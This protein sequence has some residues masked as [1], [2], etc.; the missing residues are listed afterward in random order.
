MGS[1]ERRIGTVIGKWRVNSVLG[2]GSM[3]SV[4]GVTHRNGSRAALKV[5]HAALC[6]DESLVERFFS[7]GYLA[8]VVTHPGI[9]R[10][11]D[12]GMTE[13]GCP[14]LAMEL[15]RGETLEE[16]RLRLGGSLPV[17]VALGITDSIL[18]VLIAV[19]GGD[20]I[21][22]DLKPSNVFLT[23]SGELK[24]LD[25]GVAKLS[26]TK[27]SSKGSLAG[28]VLGTPAYMSPE[29]AAGTG[30]ELDV[31]ADLFAV[32]AIMFTMLSGEHVHPVEG[33]QKKLLAAATMRARPV[34]AVLPALPEEIANVIDRALMFKKEDRWPSAAQMRAA[35][36]EARRDAVAREGPESE[37]VV[38]ARPVQRDS[39]LP[40]TAEASLP[41]VPRATM[42]SYVSFADFKP[43]SSRGPSPSY[44]SFT[45]FGSVPPPPPKVPTFGGFASVAPPFSKSPVPGPYGEAGVAPVTGLPAVTTSRIV[46]LTPPA[47]DAVRESP[48]PPPAP[49]FTI[50]PPPP[51]GDAPR[52]ALSAGDAVAALAQALSKHDVGDLVLDYLRSS[53][54]CG[55]VFTMRETSLVG[56]K[57]FAPNATEATIHALELPAAVPSAL[58][59][60]YEGRAIFRG[61]PPAE[62]A[63]LHGRLF[64][65]LGCPAPKELIVAPIVLGKRVVNLVYAHAHGGGSLPANAAVDLT[66]VC[67]AARDAYARLITRR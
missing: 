9:L 39:P 17:D 2:S 5:L 7:E 33:V 52:P 13:D 44:A 55:I 41:P 46:S 49:F 67:D 36:A 26:T 3:A 61:A 35:L 22:R 59:I 15:L 56:W 14:F 50:A 31:R 28:V 42:P 16:H 1:E 23:S 25:F 62:G 10:V 40:R 24:L 47:P 29:Q 6:R 45:G 19:H 21:H 12:D 64:R 43:P 48:P 63:S 54:E 37:A 11:F 58:R 38:L 27:R 66:S 20:V 34:E 18:D 53:Y 30:A 8:N 60:A 32:G 65:A 51:P 57:G 4:F